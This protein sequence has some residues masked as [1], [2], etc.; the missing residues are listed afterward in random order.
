MADPRRPDALLF[1]LGGVV[2]DLDFGRVLARWA[3]LADVDP[4]QLEERFSFDEAYERHERGQIDAARFFASLRAT[5]GVDLTD[6]ELLDGWNDVYLGPI[7]EVVEL[8][9]TIAD[10]FPLY[11]FTN[12]NRSHEAHWSTRFESELAPFREVFVSSTI[13]LRKP[14]PEAF[15]HIASA[16]GVSLDRIHFFDDLEENVSAAEAVGMTA[17]LVR[18]PED[19]VGTIAR[20]D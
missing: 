4:A 20:W 12:S 16:I 3:E 14:E 13:G 17:T 19:V 6:A 7:A 1:D 2:I 10:R 15:A 9:G 5:L 8:L 18:S 11:A